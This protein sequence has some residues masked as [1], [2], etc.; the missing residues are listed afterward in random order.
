[1]PNISIIIPT[2]NSEH[3]ID[4]TIQSVINQTYKDWELIIVDDLSKDNTSKILEK[5]QKK[6]SRIQLI[7]LDKNS[8]GPAHPKNVA[9]LKAVGKYVAYLD[10]DDEWLPQKL[11][12]QIVLIENNNSVGLVSCGALLVNAAGK[13]FGSYT[14]PKNKNIFPEILLRNPIHSNSSVIVRLEIIKEI[15]SRDEKIK[16]AEDW[17]M[18]IRIAKAGYRFA[19][20]HEPLFKY[21]FHSTNATILFGDYEKINDAEYIFNK[22]LD[23]YEKFNIL[24]FE[25]FR[26]GIMFLLAKNGKKSRYNFIQ[27]INKNRFFIPAYI[28]YIL[29]LLGHLGT[30]IVQIMIFFFKKL[31]RS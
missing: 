4:K 15:G 21:N 29:S 28:G 22:H 9:I 13:T 11:E 24:H 30:T 1:M 25:L 5:W 7:F 6:D 18:W 17:D 2:Y 12:K 27:S 16:G 23:L 31:R 19:F 3:F 26:L 14:P 20:V 10:H 8:G